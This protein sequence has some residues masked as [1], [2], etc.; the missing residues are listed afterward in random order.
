MEIPPTL[1]GHEE[2]TGR[3][4]GI[5]GDTHRV[6]RVGDPPTNRPEL[7]GDLSFPFFEDDVPCDRKPRRPEE[8]GR[9]AHL[10]RQAE[11]LA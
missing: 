7:L 11:L 9:A 8:L 2:R 1:P 6:G 3:R 4:S 5:R 10:S